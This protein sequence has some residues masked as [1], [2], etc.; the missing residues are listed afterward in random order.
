MNVLHCRVN[1]LEN[2]FIDSQPSIGWQVESDRRGCVQTSYRI[3]VW[4]ESKECLVYDSKT[5]P[6]KSCLPVHIPMEVQPLARYLYQVEVQ[7]QFGEIAHSDIAEFWGAKRTQPFSGKWITGHFCEKREEV[8]GAVYLRKPFDNVTGCRRALLVICGLGYFEATLN[9]AKVGDDFLSTP[10]TDFHL[11]AQYRVFDVTR[12]L[13]AKDN[14]LGVKLGNGL[15]NCFTED[16]WQ[17]SRAI[18]R[19][20]PKLVCELHLYDDANRETVIN[21]DHTWRSSTGPILLNGLR[22]GEIY[23]ARLEQDGWDRPGF[24]ESQHGTWKGV[25]MTRAPGGVLHVMEMEPIRCF[26]RIRPVEKWRTEKGWLIDIGQSQSGISN[27]TFHGRTGE[28]I[29]VRYSDLIDEHG[30]LDQKSLSMFIKNHAFQTDQYTKRSDRPETWHATFA[31][32]GFRYM[33]ISGNDWEPELDDFEIWSLCNDYE[34][35]GEFNCSDIW[36][37]RIQQAACNSTR[38]MGFSV[39]ASDTVREKTSWTGDTGLSCDQMLMNYGSEAFFRKWMQDLRDAQTPAGMLPCIIPT[40]GWGFTFANGPDWS[41]P[42][43]VVPACLYRHSGDLQ[44]LADNYDAHFRYV[45]YLDTMAVDHIVNFGLGDWCAPFDGPALTVNMIKFKC[46]V[47]LSDT[48]YYYQSVKDLAFSAKALGKHD[49][50]VVHAAHAEEIRQAFRQRFFDKRTYTAA[51]DCQTSTGMMVFFGLAYPEEIP[52][53]MERLREQ[54]RRDGGKLDFGILGMKAVLTAMGENGDAQLAL[55]MLTAPEYPSIVD[56]LKRG[57]TT[58][59]ECWNGG[60]SHNHHMFSSVSDFLYRF[61]AGISPS[62]NEIAYEKTLFRPMLNGRL[63]SAGAEINSVRG[64]VGCWWAKFED[65]FEVVIQVPVSCRG[66][67]VLPATWLGQDV[68]TVLR[69]GGS[70]VAQVS[71]ICCQKG[72]EKDIRLIVPSGEYHFSLK[73]T[74]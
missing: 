21:S 14:V 66:E 45:S 8:L 22:H 65:G 6:S 53:L 74:E 31:Y 38:S 55:D 26:R 64:K 49:E 24:D 67:L 16:P 12:L 43:H 7:N 15:Y 47:A 5:V 59:W 25:K 11:Q 36:V 33:E 2:P 73:A 1:N 44:A 39:M 29:T 13:T 48:A 28:T 19:D 60:G 70:P 23:D 34:E 10:L 17:T 63:E 57:A 71:H 41:Q 20:V 4:R 37:N 58:L 46:P 52:H 68:L 40:P 56:W 61:V 50:A 72:S 3:R 62:K 9:G 18:W 51:G 54:I 69:E 35:R 42:M 30:E 27:T 32:H